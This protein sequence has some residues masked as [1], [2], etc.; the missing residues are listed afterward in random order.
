MKL[1][2][3]N[4]FFRLQLILVV[5]GTI[6]SYSQNRLYPLSFKANQ[7]SHKDYY[8]EYY[9]KI[10]ENEESYILVDPEGRNVL[11]RSFDTIIKNAYFIKGVYQDSVFLYRCQNL[12]SIKIKGIQQAYFIQDG[13]EVLSYKGAQY[14]D[15]SI[16]K[17]DNFPLLDF[18]KCGTVYSK[19][20]SIKQ[21]KDTK[22]Y[23]VF[24]SE[25][26]FGTERSETDLELVGVPNNIEKVT[27]LDETDYISESVNSEY[28]RF[29][30]LLNIEKEGKNGIYSYN[31]KESIYPEKKEEV[32]PEY[33]IDEVLGDTIYEPIEIEPLSFVKKGMVR[34][35][36][37]FPIIYDRIQMN[38][39]NGLVYLYKDGM[40][41]I[42]PKHPTT[43]FEVFEQ[44]TTSF[45]KIR[46]H[47]K[48]GW[49]DIRTFKEYYF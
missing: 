44:K 36:E 34:I 10:Q 9:Y 4:I 1:K 26:H 2:L 32:K 30:S 38:S 41:G 19:E 14:Y 23:S 5:F 45:Y 31:I 42:Y 25:G 40:I 49:I 18:F 15:N 8:C 17:I 35:Q 39:N 28:K 27:F 13:L 24:L 33:F 43:S 12:K 21:H 11:Q 7:G 47:K 20:Y 46:K 22:K 16:S 48:Q 6:N 3:S 37:V 29:P